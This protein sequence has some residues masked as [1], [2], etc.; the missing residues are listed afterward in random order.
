MDLQGLYELDK[1]NVISY[2]KSAGRYYHYDLYTSIDGEEWVKVGG[3]DHNTP[4]TIY[5]ETF[6]LSGQG[7]R[8][9]YLKLVGLFNSANSAYHVNEIRAYGTE[10]HV[11]AFGEWTLT[12]APTCTE[13]GEES[14][15]C[16]SCGET[17]TRTVE[18]LGHSYENGFCVRCGA[19]DP[20]YVEVIA[21]GWSGYTT[22]VLTDDGCLTFTSSGEKLE[23]G[24]SNLKNYWKVN[25]V[26]TLPWS[27]YAESITKVVIND[28]IHDIGQMAFYE[29]PNLTEVVLG[30]DVTEIRNYAF[31]N[32]ASLVSINLEHVDFIREGAFYGCA[33][34][35]NIELGT[36]VVVEY[37]AFTKTPVAL[38]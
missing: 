9:A 11:H 13:A 10:V 16:E 19:E 37:W 14:R 24:E 7:I 25:G 34:L 1:L 5:G 31:K 18:M 3:K 2:W 35:E 36:S 30:K 12:K 26:L 27:D 15:T 17:E 28:G 29:L 22:W 8:A 4:E 6:D 38:P 23:N 33:A 21:S 20:D 32:C